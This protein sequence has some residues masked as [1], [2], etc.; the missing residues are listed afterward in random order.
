MKFRAEQ[1]QIFDCL[2]KDVQRAIS[3]R[4]GGECSEI[5][6]GAEHYRIRLFYK[7]KKIF[8]KSAK[9]TATTTL[10][11][12]IKA[13]TSNLTGMKTKRRLSKESADSF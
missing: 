3:D 8:K 2:C 4:H 7:C 12:K 5:L 13:A 10:R 9:P 1:P 6:T 11:N